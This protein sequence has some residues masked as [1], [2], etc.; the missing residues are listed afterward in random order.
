MT[1]SSTAGS[2]D[3]TAGGSGTVVRHAKAQ[4]RSRSVSDMKPGALILWK[5][6]RGNVLCA[7]L[8]VREWQ[9]RDGPAL[10][11]EVLTAEGKR[12]QLPV[13]DSYDLAV[14]ETLVR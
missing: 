8:E 11:L 1:E 13:N 3:I 2:A 6:A 9:D 14:V 4:S 7:V 5:R 10:M 12:F